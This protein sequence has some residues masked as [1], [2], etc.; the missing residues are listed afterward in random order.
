MSKQSGRPGNKEAI[1]MTIKQNLFMLNVAVFILPLL[2]LFV[3]G[4]LNNKIQ[5]LRIDMV[6]MGK[7]F[8]EI[9]TTQREAQFEINNHL[10]D[11]LTKIVRFE[12]DRIKNTE[13][14]TK[15]AK[16]INMKFVKLGYDSEL[17]AHCHFSRAEEDFVLTID[18]INSLKE[19]SNNE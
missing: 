13:L 16:I 4:H 17:I 2:F 11:R 7:G 14:C 1:N 8:H 12:N 19:G 6:S 10:Y 18:Q 9:K 3:S 15:L 5:N